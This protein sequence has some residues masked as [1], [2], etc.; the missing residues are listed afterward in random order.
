MEGVALGMKALVGG[1][2]GESIVLC[3][4]H[5]LSMDKISP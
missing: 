2:V 3:G 1:A 5:R 4:L